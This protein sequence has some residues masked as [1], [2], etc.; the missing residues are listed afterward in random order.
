[1]EQEQMTIDAPFQLHAQSDGTFRVWQVKHD[2]YISE[3]QYQY[4]EF[5]AAGGVPDTVPYVAPVEPVPYVASAEVL[6]LRAAYR[7]ATRAFC[8]LAGV[9]ECDKLDTAQYQQAAATAYANNSALAGMLA[10]TL[11]YALGTLRLDDGR[12]A[13]DKI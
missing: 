1:M 2:R 4:L 8:R 7:E 5:I 11:I 3:L 9:D 6:A 10:D 13:W 12:D